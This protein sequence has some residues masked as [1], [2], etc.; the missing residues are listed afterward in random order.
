MWKFWSRSDRWRTKRRARKR[1][2]AAARQR[3]ILLERLEDRSLLA[4]LINSGTAADV[5][6][7]LPASANTVFLEDDGTSG[8]G[9]LQ[10]RSGSGTFDTTVFANP[11]GSLTINRGSAADSITINN[12][13]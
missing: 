2:T 5:V 8:N 13:P 10:L 11:A 4:Q 1:P 9:M 3:R 12:L 7:T 6:Y